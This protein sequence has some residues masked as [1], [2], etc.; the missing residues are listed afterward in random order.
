MNKCIWE[1]SKFSDS[2]WNVKF[3]E[4]DFFNYSMT[5]LEQQKFKIYKSLGN[6]KSISWSD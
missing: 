3:H 1:I 6:V 5:K 2:P 4:V